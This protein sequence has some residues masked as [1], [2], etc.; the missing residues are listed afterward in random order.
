MK[1]RCNIGWGGRIVRALTG[2]VLL[3]DAYLLYRYKMPGE[4]WWA[5]L[6]QLALAAMGAFAL[7]EGIAGWCAVRAL[8]IRTRF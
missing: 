5:H 6:L 4:S 3:A 2:I 8:G 1:I 7:F